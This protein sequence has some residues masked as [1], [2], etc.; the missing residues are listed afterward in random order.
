[1]SI[2]GRSKNILCLVS[3]GL[4][5]SAT[6]AIGSVA[7]EDSSAVVAIHA[8]SVIDGLSAESLGPSVILIEGERITEVDPDVVIPP[9]ARE[10]NLLDATV[11][12]QSR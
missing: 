11:L 5:A 2:S 9:G 12:P 3:A 10:I 1:M 7:Q 8:G 6:G 4:I